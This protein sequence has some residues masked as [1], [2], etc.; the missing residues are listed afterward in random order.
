MTHVLS[1]NL[2]R[3][4]AFVYLVVS[5]LMLKYVALICVAVVAI[6]MTASANVAGDDGGYDKDDDDEDR[7]LWD[8]N[9]QHFY[10]TTCCLIWL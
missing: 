7:Y 4:H 3:L 2:V 6:L 5:T 8:K 10:D 9:E 1:L